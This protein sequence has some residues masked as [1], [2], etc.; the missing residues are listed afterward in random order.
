MVY[1]NSNTYFLE[2]SFY[3]K[4]GEAITSSMTGFTNIVHLHFQVL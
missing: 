4:A 3:V 2:E 1:S